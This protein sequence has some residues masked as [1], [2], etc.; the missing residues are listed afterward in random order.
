MCLQPSQKPD[1]GTSTQYVGRSRHAEKEKRLVSVGTSGCRSNALLT[2]GYLEAL[3]DGKIG[4]K[5]VSLILAVKA[6]KKL[7]FLMAMGA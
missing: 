6:E 4:D 1:K 3:F 5:L 7:D 2:H